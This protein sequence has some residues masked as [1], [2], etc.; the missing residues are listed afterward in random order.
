MAAALHPTL[1]TDLRA[2]FAGEVLTPG[3]G[4]YDQA[5]TVFNAMIDRHPQ[6]I[7]QCANPADVA[8][9]IAFGRE[10]GLE[11]AVR[12][13]G[14]AVS[15]ASVNDGLV[16]DLRRMNSVVVDPEAGVARV[17][18]GALMSDLDRA[19]QPYGLATTGGRDS[20]TGVAGL[21]LGGGSGWLERK[22]GLACDN[23]L[24]VKLVTADG[25][26][27]AADEDRHPELFWALHGGG[28]N[29]GV[30]TEL[31]FEL[32]ELPAVTV[33]MLVW[34]PE[35]GPR[36]MRHFVDFMATAPEEVGGGFVYFTGP[37][38]DF[39]PAGL[40]GR[41]AAA[42]LLTYTGG[43]AAAREVFRPM[44]A[45]GHAGEMIA[46]LPYADFQCML[47]DPPGERNYWSAEYLNGFPAEA[48][49]L[50]CARAADMVVPSASM[51]AF[52]PM[53]GAVARGE[54]YPVPWRAA[55]WAV[56]PFG[57]WADPAD[58]ARGRQWARDV[59]SDL[60][61][62]SIGAVYLNFIGDEG[63]DRV[64]AGLGTGNA[65]RLAAVKSAYDPEN[66]FHL[67][68]NIVPA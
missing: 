24:S 36:V 18:G 8:A 20:S 37:P 11:I 21:T 39:V 51:H 40:V 34:Q 52:F 14:H 29:F 15:G 42:A 63:A 44:L 17:G 57:V 64:A 7:A 49:D 3:D 4:E 65:R 46:E 50:F 26:L 67:N 33:A 25:E 12:A 19:T 47:D 35:A 22:W 56:H 9:A 43:E 1:L 54:D 38:E 6:L 68:H 31:T 53:G 28:G 59:R 13:G 58:D 66:V 60:L 45:Y 61:P 10:Q 2:G 41:L 48:V 27:V 5:R 16:I 62:W 32:H 30:A 23:L 55:P